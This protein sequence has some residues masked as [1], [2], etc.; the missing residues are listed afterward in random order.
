MFDLYMSS[1]SIVGLYSAITGRD[2]KAFIPCHKYRHVDH[3]FSV[4]LE[5]T[6]LYLI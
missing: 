3:V 2:I 4:S 6:H 5:S 1:Y